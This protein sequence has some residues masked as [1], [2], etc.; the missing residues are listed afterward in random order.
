VSKAPDGSADVQVGVVSWGSDC[1]N[2][3]F[4]GVYARVSSLY[5]WIR[6][7]VC[8]RS[9]YPSASLR[10]EDLPTASPTLTRAPSN[11]PV[12]TNTPTLS[13]APTTTVP[14][15]TPYNSPSLWDWGLETTSTCTG[16]TP[17]WADV[18]GFGCAVYE[19]IDSPS[20]PLF[21]NLGDLIGGTMGT[22][23]DNCCYCFGT[24]APVITA[25]PTPFPTLPPGVTRV[26]STTSPTYSPWT[27]DWTHPMWNTNPTPKPTSPCTGST[28][29]WQD[30]WGDACDWYE[31]NDLPD[32][33]LGEMYE[34]TMGTANDN[35][36]Y[37]DSA[38]TSEPFEPASP[39]TGNTP[40]WIDDLDNGCE[41][42]E[43]H[44]LPGCP[45]FGEVLEGT[46][47]AANDNCCY[48]SGDGA[49]MQI[50]S[51]AEDASKSTSNPTYDVFASLEPGAS[52]TEEPTASP[53]KDD[54]VTVK[55]TS[56]PEDDVLVYLE[57]TASP[58][59]DALAEP[60]SG[61]TEDELEALK[62]TS[63]PTEDISLPLEPTATPM[64][65]ELEGMESTLSPTED[66]F[67]SLD[68]NPAATFGIE[69]ALGAV[70]VGDEDQSEDTDLQ[71]GNETR[72]AVGRVIS[73]SRS[74]LD[75][76]LISLMRTF[77]SAVCAGSLFL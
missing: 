63:I 51:P 17:G 10:C 19:L 72:D 18:L 40:G 69:L 24:G 9:S 59:E 52:P 16:N 64:E 50:A 1:A 44:D 35:C 46:M 55:P 37:C 71:L 23:N 27:W 13:L 6:E 7:E 36:C 74:T 49:D 38:S 73:G 21:G 11:S 53:T 39:C 61:P 56:S 57:P 48:C 29:G 32:C 4:P 62:A 70:P 34:G 66:V 30:I 14:P 3:Q 25:S 28:P 26:P 15:S 12:P 33:P 43:A 20:C 54:L 22:A 45:Y 65:D 47:G 42:Y 41:F 58:T 68:A 67:A 8:K 77:A 76:S 31:N 2:P 60:T 75:F 5:A